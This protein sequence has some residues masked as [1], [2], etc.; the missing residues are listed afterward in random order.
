MSPRATAAPDL[1]GE[2]REAQERAAEAAQE[3]QEARERAS[4]AALALDERRAARA[5]EHDRQWLEVYDGPASQRK[6]DTALAAFREAIEG[7]PGFAAFVELQAEDTRYYVEAARAQGLRLSL[8]LP[9]DAAPPPP[10]PP[11]ATFADRFVSAATVWASEAAVTREAER[12]EKADGE[13][14][15]F[16]AVEEEVGTAAPLAYRMPT[17]DEHRP[18]CSGSRVERAT[19]DHRGKPAIVTRC[20]NCGASETTWPEGR[21]V[22]PAEPDELPRL[23]RR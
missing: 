2:A 22:P 7:E 6:V 11:P 19:T 23:R 15:A 9:V 10:P 13:R 14:E 18:G 21:P 5:A 4:R 12:R 8:G 16:V 17:L 20:Q 1:A 3:A